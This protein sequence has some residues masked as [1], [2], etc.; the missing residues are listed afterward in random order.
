[1]GLTKSPWLRQRILSYQ[2]RGGRAAGS[3]TLGM[4]HSW[5]REKLPMSFTDHN[6]PK[7]AIHPHGTTHPG[8]FLPG[9]DHRH[10]SL[11][12]CP[13]DRLPLNTTQELAPAYPFP[14][15]VSKAAF[16]G[17]KRMVKLTNVS[18]NCVARQ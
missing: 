6:W 14:K 15:I 17:P 9:G 5:R 1:M 18:S 16:G 4:S 12:R 2:P 13:A 7:V 8:S 11:L 3:A 10:N